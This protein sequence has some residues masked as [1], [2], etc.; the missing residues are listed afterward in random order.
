MILAKN[1]IQKK[2]LNHLMHSKYKH[3]CCTLLINYIY[4]E[5]ERERNDMSTI[6][7]PQILSGRLLLVVIIGIKK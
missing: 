6:F 3:I 1:N 2:K 4:I 7:S 5:R